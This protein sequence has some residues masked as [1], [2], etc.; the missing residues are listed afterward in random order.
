M[1]KENGDRLSPEVRDLV[2]ELR[3]HRVEWSAAELDRIKLQAMARASRGGGRSLRLG[4]GGSMRS[5]LIAVLVVGLLGAGTAGTIAASGGGGGS[6]SAAKSQYKPGC[7]P[8]KNDGVAGN[9]GRHVGQ[10]PKDQDRGDCPNPP[11]QN[12]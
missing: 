12:K 1:S 2:E 3:A 10:P 5:R 6:K 4:K 9:S 11:G 7:G 8:D